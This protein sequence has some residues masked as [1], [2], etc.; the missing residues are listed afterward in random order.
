MVK[1]Q[2]KLKLGRKASHKRALVKNLLRSL[3]TYGYLTT[4]TVKAKAL[5]MEASKLIHDL[6]NSNPSVL[7]R[8]TSVLGDRKITEKAVKYLEKNEGLI[9]LLKIGYRDGDKAQTSRVTLVGFNTKKE[10]KT[11]V[12]KEDVKKEEKK[13]VKKTNRVVDVVKSVSKKVS[14]VVTPKTQRANTRS[15]L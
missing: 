14:N 9:K 6:K 13:E 4:T 7:R 3:F 8:I 12:E 15:G 11:K 2:K 10:Q 1:G 5:K